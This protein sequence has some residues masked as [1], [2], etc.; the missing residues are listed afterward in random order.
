MLIF[1]KNN[2]GYLFAAHHFWRDSY[3]FYTT[4]S[5]LKREFI[6][7]EGSRNHQNFHSCGILRRPINQE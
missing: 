6:P 1:I 7:D 2:R 4:L 5:S 3:F